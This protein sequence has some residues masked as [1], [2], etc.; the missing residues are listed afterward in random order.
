[1]GLVPLERRFRNLKDL[2]DWL[3]ERFPLGPVS[4]DDS[5]PD[6]MFRAGQ[7]VLAQRLILT[8]RAT[9][10]DGLEGELDGPNSISVET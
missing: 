8:I 4:P 1:M 6:I 5:M 10:P 7:Q 9:D 3:E 2:A